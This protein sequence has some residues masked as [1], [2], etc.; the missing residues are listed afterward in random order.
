M[1]QHKIYFRPNS[2]FAE[3]LNDIINLEDSLGNT[4]ILKKYLI[5]ATYQGTSELPKF[6]ERAEWEGEGIQGVMLKTA[7]AF[8]ITTENNNPNLTLDEKI[9]DWVLL[10]SMNR[11]EEISIIENYIG[12]GYP[13]RLKDLD[14][15]ELKKIYEINNKIH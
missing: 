9:W 11:S 3:R 4:T 7:T 12:Y 6:F 8:E 2:D 15:A 5:K 10:K 14:K 13:R 1:I